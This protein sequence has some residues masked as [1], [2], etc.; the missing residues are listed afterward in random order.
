[1]DR[2]VFASYV[3]L[4]ETILRLFPLDDLSRRGFPVE[5][6]DLSA[7]YGAS[8]PAKEVVRP[9]TRR[10]ASWPELEAALAGPGAAGTMVVVAVPYEPRFFRLYRLL[11]RSA[12]RLGSV[13]SGVL[14]MPAPTGLDRVRQDARL[15]LDPARVAHFLLKRAALAA[16]RMG[17]VR[18]FDAVFAAGAAAR[19]E[20][21]HAPVVPVN[22]GDYDDWLEH[23]DDDPRLVEGRYAVYLDQYATAHPDFALLGVKRLIDPDRYHALLDAFFT[24]LERR[25]GVEV[26]IAAHPKADYA[27]NPFGGRLILR[28]STRALVRRC[29]FAL[30]TISTSLGFAV[31][32]RKPLVFFTTEEMMER[33]RPL[34]HDVAPF[35]FA[36]ALGRTCRILDRDE[37]AEIEPVDAALYDD[38]KYR[39]LVSRET[40]GRL[41][42]DAYREYFCSLGLAPGPRP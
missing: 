29:E 4:T 34:R 22:A 32:D 3:T 10:F 23:K 7:L 26:V 24:R 18:G 1:M 2:I 37:G 33:Y 31:L 12:A 27:R 39:Y 28:S 16:R 11:S 20:A 8:L 5:Y 13:I 42:R 36:R 40:E 35:H 30:A 21:G 6:W 15:L 19:E 25:H 14:P 41:S 17:A 9:Y 38:Y